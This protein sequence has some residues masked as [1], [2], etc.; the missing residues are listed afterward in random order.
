MSCLDSHSDGTHS[1][2]SIHCWASDVMLHFSKSDEET[3]SSTS[4]MILMLSIMPNK[5][6]LFSCQVM[7]RTMMRPRWDSI[8]DHKNISKITTKICFKEG[9]KRLNV[10]VFM[11]VSQDISELYQIFSDEVLGSGQFGVVY[12]GTHRHTGRPVAVKVI[13]K[14]R[15][16]TKQEEQSKNEVSILQVWVQ[17]AI[18]PTIQTL[19]LFLLLLYRPYV[20]VSETVSSRSHSFRRDV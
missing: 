15:F 14:T 3:N 4:S 16:P 1:L 8:F 7:E 20:C 19:V 6:H 12:G 17:D 13:D 2:Q 5:W 9:M 11:C 18:F 10:S